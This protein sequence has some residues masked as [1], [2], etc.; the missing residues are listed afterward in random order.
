M[1]RFDPNNK[2]PYR[3]SA[4]ERDVLDFDEAPEQRPE[5]TREGRSEASGDQQRQ[6]S[7]R[8]AQ[9]DARRDRDDFPRSRR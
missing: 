8:D 5:D 6:P 2:S 1:A 3:D 7:Q 9:R 4:D